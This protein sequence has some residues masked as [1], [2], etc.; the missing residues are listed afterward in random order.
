VRGRSAARVGRLTARRRHINSHRRAMRRSARAPAQRAAA[1]MKNA[2]PGEGA[3]RVDAGS[4]PASTAVP[5]LA[6]RITN[7]ERVGPFGTKTAVG[8]FALDGIGQF[9]FEIFMPQGKPLRSRRHQFAVNIMAS[10]HELFGSTPTSAQRCLR[11]F[12][13]SSTRTT[14]LDRRQHENGDGKEEWGRAA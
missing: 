5:S 8:T 4:I 7:L 6:F 2:S 9:D 14:G 12:F 3:R 13:R 11:Q 1:D 10:T